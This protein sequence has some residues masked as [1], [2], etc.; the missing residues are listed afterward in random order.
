M[1]KGRSIG[2]GELFIATRKRKDGT[3]I[4]EE[5]KTIAV[6][7]YFILKIVH[8]MLHSFVSYGFLLNYMLKFIG[9][10]FRETSRI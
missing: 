3:Y 9:A 10:S 4:S 2:R 1:E 5:A 8:F 7:S 6:I